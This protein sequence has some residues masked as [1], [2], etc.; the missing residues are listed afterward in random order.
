MKHGIG[1][2]VPNGVISKVKI[3][4]ELTNSLKSKTSSPTSALL[5]VKTNFLTLCDLFFQ[6]KVNNIRRV[7]VIIKHSHHIDKSTP[8]TKNK[9]L[10]KNLIKKCFHQII[11]PVCAFKIIKAVKICIL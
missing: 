9:K 10:A 2:I 5:L 8:E 3:L 6:I 11:S 1:D 7:N 4:K